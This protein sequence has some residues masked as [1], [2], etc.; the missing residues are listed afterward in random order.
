MIQPPSAESRNATRAALSRGKLGRPNG[1]CRGELRA[2][3]VGDPSC[4]GRPWIDAVGADSARAELR[5]GRHDDAVEGALAHAVG[6]VVGERVAGECDDA[7]VGAGEPVGKLL[8]EQRDR[9]GVHR[10]MSIELVRR[11]LEQRKRDVSAVRGDQGRERPQPT[12]QLVEEPGRRCRVAQIVLGDLRADAKPTKLLRELQRLLIT[13]FE[14]GL[15]V[16]GSPAAEPHVPAHLGEPPRARRR[17]SLASAGAGDEDVRHDQPSP[18]CPSS[19]G[20][21]SG[22]DSGRSCRHE[23]RRCRRPSARTT[24]PSAHGGRRPGARV[25]RGGFP[26]RSTRSR[27]GRPRR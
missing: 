23:P 19:S 15:S 8:D 7:P 10:E 20:D 24:G 3:L 18:S 21:R 6:D 12:F 17:D 25:G 26:G 14:T 13:A 2:E 4:F 9:A 11:R 1:V 22:R 16:V 5:C 27:R